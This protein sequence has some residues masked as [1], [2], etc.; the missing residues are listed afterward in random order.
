MSSLDRRLFCLAPLALAA[1]GFEPVYAPGGSGSDLQ[2]RVLVSAPDDNDSYFL[3]R[4]LEERLGR[5]DTP[6]YTLSLKLRTQEFGL[7]IDED[8]NIDR[9]NI[10]GEADYVLADA[11]SGAQVSSGT[12]Q[13]FTGYS[14]T[15]STVVTLA[16]ERDARERLMT[17]LADQITTRLLTV[18]LA[19]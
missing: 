9:F 19:E 1:C 18:D 4:R 3:V 16:S 17:I 8:G 14:A 15:G 13:A 6:E 10:T 12:V 2:G 11:G 7:G 5:G